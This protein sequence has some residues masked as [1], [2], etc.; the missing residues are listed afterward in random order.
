[1]QVVYDAYNQVNQADLTPHTSDLSL[2]DAE[3]INNTYSIELHVG[4]HGTIPQEGAHPEHD[5]YRPT[6][7]EYTE[8]EKL[9]AGMTRGDVLF[10]EGLG[11]GRQYRPPTIRP[12]TLSADESQKMIAEIGWAKFAGFL[13]SNH[14]RKED[15][16]AMLA[17]ARK[18]RSI[19]AWE[20]AM[21][22][23]DT[24]G[25]EV[26][27]ADADVLKQR[28][29]TELGNEDPARYD[30]LGEAASTSRELDARNIVKDW[31]LEHPHPRRSPDAARKPKLVV[32]WGFS[33]KEGLENAFDEV[34]L[35]TTTFELDD[36]TADIKY[37]EMLRNMG[38]SAIPKSALGPKLLDGRKPRPSK[39]KNRPKP[40]SE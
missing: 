14:R 18:Q 10:V 33:H 7:L 2:E 6:E 9:L 21:G 35:Q 26:V 38:K 8:V 32:L 31:V 23:A 29:L 4:A 5:L 20:Y 12:D 15:F 11:F 40:G 36:S 22:L 3:R 37:I 28:Y 34:N 16:G 27:H 17:E 19:T 39:F 25:I 1:M 13:V 24:R 30:L